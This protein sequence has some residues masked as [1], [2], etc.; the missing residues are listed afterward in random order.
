ML[1]FRKKKEKKN[2]K[3]RVPPPL[4]SWVLHSPVVS[5]RLSIPRMSLIKIPVLHSKLS[6]FATE[7]CFCVIT[8]IAVLKAADLSITAALDNTHISGCWRYRGDTSQTSSWAQCRCSFLTPVAAIFFP[9]IF[10]FYR[11]ELIRQSD[12]DVDGGKV[13]PNASTFLLFS[14]FKW[15]D[16]IPAIV[17]V[18]LAFHVS[19]GFAGIFWW[20]TSRLQRSQGLLSFSSLWFF[21]YYSILSKSFCIYLPNMYMRIRHS[22]IR[23]YTTSCI[24]QYISIFKW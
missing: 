12:K 17:G 5:P 20:I 22:S 21:F 10:F 7:K 23:K 1:S 4:P 14:F 18:G 3:K 9:F 11:Q 2:H 24:F 19:S 15:V 16:W 8:V 13:A 6:S